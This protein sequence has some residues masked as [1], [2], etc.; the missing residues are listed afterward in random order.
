VIITPCRRNDSTVGKPRAFP[1]F[2]MEWHE[3]N[4]HRSQ[5]KDAAG[6]FVINAFF[7]SYKQSASRVSV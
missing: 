7:M 1:R 5:G 3:R 6:D 2:E 4:R